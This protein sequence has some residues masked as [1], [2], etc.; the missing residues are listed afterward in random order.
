MLLLTLPTE[1]ILQIASYLD[2][3]LGLRNINSFAQTC[4]RFYTIVDPFL[5]SRDVHSGLEQY[6]SSR[7]ALRYA[8]KHGLL[9]TADKALQAGAK[10]SITSLLFATKYHQLEMFNLLL[11]AGV[12]SDKDL[13][14]NL[15][16]A[17]VLGNV[18]MVKELLLRGADPSMG[19]QCFGQPLL[20][21]AVD[22]GRNDVFDLLL[23]DPR[24]DHNAHLYYDPYRTGVQTALE[25]AA[26]LGNVHMVQALLKRGASA[27]PYASMGTPLH[28]AVMQCSRELIELLV[29]RD[30]VDPN[31]IFNGKTPLHY[32]VS[33]NRADIVGS[34]LS[35]PYV[36]VNLTGL[37][38]R[39]TPLH[40]AVVLD[41]SNIYEY[42]I[43]LGADPHIVSRE[44]LSPAMLLEC[45]DARARNELVE[46]YRGNT[47]FTELSEEKRKRPRLSSNQY[48][49]NSSTIERV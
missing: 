44:G 26:K 14:T 6:G 19:S 48:N 42:L 45:P 22:R 17:V 15:T 30:D 34:L 28:S 16:T 20:L 7:T 9:R 24:T 32:A 1:L 4:R 8:A 3:L 38:N 35:N 5:Y 2:T 27:C 33:T 37:P 10:P 21:E 25:R 47:R 31:A 41:N 36:D 11:D 18:E 49:A 43:V 39:W 40:E 29:H 13:R 46:R 12:W 23:A